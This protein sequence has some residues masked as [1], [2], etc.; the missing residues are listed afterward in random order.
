MNIT[1]V[2]RWLDEEYGCS[3]TELEKLHDFVVNK[4]MELLDEQEEL[5]QIIDKITKENKKLKDENFKLEYQ[6]TRIKGALF[7]FEMNYYQ[8][9]LKGNVSS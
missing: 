6:N 3:F 5:L 8:D 9:N 7:E 2:N 4:N 1:T